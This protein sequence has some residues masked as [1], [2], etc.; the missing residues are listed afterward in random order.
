MSMTNTS[1][2]YGGVAKIFHWLTAFLILGLVPLGW[3]ANQLPYDTSEQLARKA[4]LFSAHKTFGVAVFFVASA[5]I[6]WALSQ[7]KPG[8]LNADHKV[9]SFLAELVHWLLYASLVIVPLS[10]WIH[11]AASQGFAPIWWPLGQSLPLVPKSP[12]VEHLFGV[13]HWWAT[14]LLVASV[15]LHIAGALKHH[16][17]DRD[18]T[19]RRM[20]PGEAAIGALPPQ[21]HSRAPVF[22]ASVLWAAT[23]G[24]A[25]LW[26]AQSSHEGPSGPALAEVASD[27]QV[28]N[29]TLALTVKQFG[30]DVTGSFADWQAAI[31][32]DETVSD[33]PA[34]EVD[35][36]ISI[37]SLTLGSVTSQALGPDFFD[38]DT[39]ATA[40]FTGPILRSVD[41]YSV[42]GTLSIKET[43]V[44]IT[45]PFSLAIK[46]NIADMQ[47]HLKLDR[48][49]FGIGDT[50][51]D[52]ASLGFAVDITIEL[53][54]QQV[55]P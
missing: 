12:G 35:V 3:Y 8:L 44:P 15:L 54:A 31:T 13:L 46:D 38:A 6:L 52:D 34:G 24:L 48:R 43:S 5:R 27:W 7:P 25:L 53:R 10:G 51:T 18:P 41:G 26:A 39:F 28:Q 37:P 45:L 9:E 2:R 22:V 23:A 55:S 30:S 17:V 16:F 14:K 20:L 32:F 33:G 29:G 50:M 1:L 49:D 42:D 19:L 21:H 47:G 4:W 11:H 36:T 40:Q